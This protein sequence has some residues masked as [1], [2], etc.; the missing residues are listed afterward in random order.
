MA[1]IHNNF[2]ADYSAGL[3]SQTR[4]HLSKI[5]FQMSRRFWEDEEIYGGITST[6][7]EINEIWYPSHGI[8]KK[9]GI[10]LGAYLFGFSRRPGTPA[11]FFEKMTPQERLRFAAEQGDNIHAGYSGYI[12]NGVSIPWARM[13]HMMGCGSNMTDEMREKYFTRLQKPEGRHYMV[14]DQIS[15]HSSWQEGAFASAEYALQDLDK[16]VRAEMAAGTGKG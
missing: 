3:A 13:N 4:G 8:F 10:V 1:G 2:P 12:E 16:R 5:G 11:N 15:F 14:G 6:G 9:K 7:Q